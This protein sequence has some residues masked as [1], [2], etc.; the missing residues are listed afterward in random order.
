MEELCIFWKVNIYEQNMCNLYLI[1]TSSSSSPKNLKLSIIARRQIWNSTRCGS[2]RVFYCGG[3]ISGKRSV[4]KPRVGH[5][6]P[7]DRPLSAVTFVYK[8]ADIFIEILK[9]L[10]LD[11]LLLNPWIGS[12]GYLLP[13]CMHTIF[14]SSTFQIIHKRRRSFIFWNNL[15]FEENQINYSSTIFCVCHPPL[16]LFPKK[17]TWWQ[18]RC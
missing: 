5:I 11:F 12:S 6:Y 15:Y 18:L 3:D 17:A 10:K 16:C 14:H 7:P 4:T 8:L 2:F 1:W 13:S 9:C